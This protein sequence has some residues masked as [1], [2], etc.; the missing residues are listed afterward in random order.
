MA[1][2]RNTHSHTDTEWTDVGW[3]EEISYEKYAA[4]GIE[5]DW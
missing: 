3:L 4:V 2:H 1:R 5:T